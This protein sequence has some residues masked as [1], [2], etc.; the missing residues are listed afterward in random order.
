[1]QSGFI[2]TVDISE[3]YGKFYGIS[4]ADGTSST[5][6]K[7][8]L[9]ANNEI[10]LLTSVFAKRHLDVPEG[11][12]LDT[13]MI[14]TVYL[15]AVVSLLEHSFDIDGCCLSDGS[16]KITQIPG[17]VSNCFANRSQYID[18]HTW[19]NPP[20]HPQFIF[21]LIHMIIFIYNV[22]RLYSEVVRL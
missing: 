2:S 22:Y 9:L 3:E 18:K 11:Y 12:W 13:Y 8:D 1:L 14:K 20:V 17:F 5:F 16:N 19:F 15:N 7:D 10:A 6:Q 21:K 4:F